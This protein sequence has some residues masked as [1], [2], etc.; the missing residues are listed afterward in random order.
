MSQ[1]LRIG[2]IGLGFMGATH[3][4][5]FRAARDAGFA[6]DLVAVCD[7][8]PSRRAGELDDVGGN[9][10]TSGRESR[11]F[12]PSIVRGY[13]RAEDLIADPGIDLI[14][15]C[16]RTDTHVELTIRALEAGK[17][18]LIEKPVALT[19]NDVR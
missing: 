3:V 19:S 13:E 8:K 10:A 9:L 17:H 18:V 11:A 1:P 2:I 12:D 4:G 7:R 5:A 16:T 14:S 15:I 6:N